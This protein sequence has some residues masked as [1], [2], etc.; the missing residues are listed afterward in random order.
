M[1]K[2]K[3]AKMAVMNCRSKKI[4]PRKS[5]MQLKRKTQPAAKKV[6]VVNHPSNGEYINP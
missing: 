2:I 3:K 5:M 1:V 6:S 4:R